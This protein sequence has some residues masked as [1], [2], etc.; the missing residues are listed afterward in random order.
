[1][2]RPSLCQRIYNPPETDPKSKSNFSSA[3]D[4]ADPRQTTG[5]YDLFPYLNKSIAIAMSTPFV[6]VAGATGMLGKLVAKEL[7]GRDIAVKALV[8]PSTDAS[9][10]EKLREIGITVAPVDLSNVTALRQE[11]Y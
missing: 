10:L 3:C 4:R 11:L 5:P 6:A 9:R 7:I 1:M 2:E 8:R